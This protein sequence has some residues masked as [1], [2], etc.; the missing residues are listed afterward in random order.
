MLVYGCAGDVERIVAFQAVERQV[1]DAGRNDRARPASVAA[2]VPA[3]TVKV[4]L[5]AV[6]LTVSVPATVEREGVAR[7]VAREGHGIEDVLIVP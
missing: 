3:A 2:P 6:P 1:L 7:A 5:A 4:S